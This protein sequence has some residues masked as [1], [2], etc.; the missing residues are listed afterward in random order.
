[1][2]RLLAAALIALTA[3]FGAT[4]CGADDKTPDA[5]ATTPGTTTSGG[6]SG[7]TAANTAQVCADA[8]KAITE[9]TTEFATAMQGITT[10]M[11]G[12]DETAKA[13]ALARTKDVFATWAAA[14]QE[15]ANKALDPE[16]KAA[17]TTL[18]AEFAS[19]TT[20]ITSFE[21]LAKLEQL[22]ESPAAEAAGEK[23]ES[24]CP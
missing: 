13:A 18:G 6:P 3:T 15:Q 20:K 16:L 10:A 8:E 22:M 7:G 12:G 21:D 14:V 2:R 23:M 24:L 11:A 1:M 4:A 19:L 17:L 9:S 5:S